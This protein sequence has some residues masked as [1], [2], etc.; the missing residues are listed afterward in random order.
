MGCALR[1]LI[2][3]ATNALALWASGRLFEG[4]SIHGGWAYVIGAVVL[5]FVNG[6]IKPILT[7][8]TLPL[9]ILTLGFFYLLINI[10]MVALTAWITPNFS[11]HGFWSYVGTVFI[12][13]LL[14]WAVGSLVD[15][16]ER[17]FS[18]TTPSPVDSLKSG[19]RARRAAALSGPAGSAG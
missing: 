11:V 3:L 16:G 8:L 1:L 9:V 14:N 17:S 15:E 7:I 19:E 10:G 4:V 6:V 13:W 18:R 5:G 2:A 12:I